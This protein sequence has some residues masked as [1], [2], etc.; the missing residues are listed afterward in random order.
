M[1]LMLLIINHLLGGKN[2]L[3]LLLSGGLGGGKK[4]GMN[5]LLLTSLLG[6]DKCEEKHA[7]CT[8]PRT[9]NANGYKSCGEGDTGAS[10][11]DGGGSYSY[12]CCPCCTCP[13]TPNHEGGCGSGAPP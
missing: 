3:P 9:A 11:M 7:R 5:P 10:C 13:D 6:D 1:Y 8:Q 2:L 4:G 12:N